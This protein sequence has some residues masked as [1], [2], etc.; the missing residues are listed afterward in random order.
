[1]NNCSHFTF[2]IGTWS[3]N[4]ILIN[5][6][7][8][9]IEKVHHEREKQLWKEQTMV[10]HHWWTNDDEENKWK[11]VKLHFYSVFEFQNWKA[12]KIVINERYE[13]NKDSILLHYVYSFAIIIFYFEIKKK[14]PKIINVYFVLVFRYNF[15]LVLGMML[16]IEVHSFMKHET[17]ALTI[18]AAAFFFVSF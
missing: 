12:N 11:M 1:M 10:I 3:P 4:K 5:Y 7:Q 17:I 6:Y 16:K 8:S 15:L 18:Y 2:T 9:E 13:W 14:K